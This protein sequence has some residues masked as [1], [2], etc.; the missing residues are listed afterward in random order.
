MFTNTIKRRWNE[1]TICTQMLYYLVQYLHTVL[2]PSIS[3]V[4]KNRKQEICHRF[5]WLFCIQANA[6]TISKIHVAIVCFSCSLPDFDYNQNR[7]PCSGGSHIMSKLF[8]SI[9][10]IPRPS[11]TFAHKTY[12]FNVNQQFVHENPG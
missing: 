9:N 4:V 8:P 10:Q 11:F 1:N 7:I 12:Y 6:H 3:S 5:S 2:T